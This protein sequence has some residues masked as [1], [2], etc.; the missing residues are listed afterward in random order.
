M[1]LI[2]NNLCK[3]N[4]VNSFGWKKQLRNGVVEFCKVISSKGDI[5]RECLFAVFFQRTHTKRC[6]MKLAAD[7]LKT[8]KRRWF[9][10]E[11]VIQLQNFLPQEFKEAKR[12]PSALMSTWR[13]SRQLQIPACSGNPTSANCWRM[14]EAPRLRS[15]QGKYCHIFIMFFHASLD[16]Q[17]QVL[18]VRGYLNG[19][20]DPV[21]TAFL[22]CKACFLF[23]FFCFNSSV[24]SFSRI[25][26][27]SS[28]QTL[29]HN[30]TLTYVGGGL[31][32]Q[33]T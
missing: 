27:T 20:F 2:G 23:F 6:L 28:T 11:R 29:G 31:G 13:K 15:I 30:K 21:S 22:C 19:P 32:P 14:L 33:A 25:L 1:E 7:E 9:S 8:D 24:D 26:T 16:I 3:R 17:Y 5:N 10:T 4:N 18:L 12:F